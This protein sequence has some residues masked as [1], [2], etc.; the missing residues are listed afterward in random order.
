MDTIQLQPT[1]G[2]KDTLI[3]TLK[4]DENIQKHFDLT[5]AWKRF[6]NISIG[7]VKRFHALM[8]NKKYFELN[9]FMVQFG[10]K[11]KYDQKS[12]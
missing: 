7:Q 4:R 12:N 5:D 1:L 2:Q 11:Q 3:E 10:F 8:F 9:A 6:E